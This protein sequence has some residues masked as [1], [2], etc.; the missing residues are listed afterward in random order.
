[1]DTSH[2]ADRAPH[3]TRPNT[4]PVGGPGGARRCRS[5]RR[6]SYCCRRGN[7]TLVPASGPDRYAHNDEVAGAL[8]SRANGNG[9]G[10]RQAT[11][12]V[13]EHPVEARPHP[14]FCGRVAD[15]PPSPGR[16]CRGERSL[17]ERVSGHCCGELRR[18]QLGDPPPR[19]RLEPHAHVRLVAALNGIRDG[20]GLTPSSVV[21]PAGRT[22]A[23]WSVRA[24]VHQASARTPG[25]RRSRRVRSRV[26][27]W[28]PGR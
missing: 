10:R 7:R 24:R 16:R 18:H 2:S 11:S 8:A 13:P 28:M 5:G 20:L 15:M 25:A 6:R 9:R 21:I 23:A 1:M 12:R 19:K 17:S 4:A 14:R 3:M 27:P 26:Q 22:T